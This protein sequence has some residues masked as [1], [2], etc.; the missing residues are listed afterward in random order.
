ILVYMVVP[1]TPDM[2]KEWLSIESNGLAILLRVVCKLILLPL[3]V[4]ISYELIKL[5]GRYTNIFTRIISAPGLWMQRLTTREPDDSQIEVA[6]AAITPC[7]PKEG[8]D[9]SW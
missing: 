8:E 5:A 3:V 7:L 1:I 2:F 9:D 4:G 6:I